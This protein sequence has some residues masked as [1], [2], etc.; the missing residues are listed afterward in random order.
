MAT[1]TTGQ[2]LT[3]LFVV[4]PVPLFLILGFVCQVILPRLWAVWILPYLVGVVLFTT[5]AKWLVQTRLA[6]VAE[7]ASY[8]GLPNATAARNLVR[9]RVC[10]Q[11]T[12]LFVAFFGPVLLLLGSHEHIISP[13]GFGIGFL[14]YFAGVMLLTAL[15]KFLERKLPPSDSQGAM[16]PDAKTLRWFEGWIWILKVWIG[17]LAV[18]LPLGIAIGIGHRAL[19]PTCVGVGINLL[20]MYVAARG[21]RRMHKLI[22]FG[23]KP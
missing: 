22:R 7:A 10:L 17:M 16:S 20:M 11:L 8:S 4:A 12:G 9:I 14:S 23:L 3:P 19:L 15:V 2:Q 21:I 18:S 1:K 5:Y 13:R 6:A